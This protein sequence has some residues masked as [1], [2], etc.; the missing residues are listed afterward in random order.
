MTDEYTADGIVSKN[1][2]TMHSTKFLRA[3]GKMQRSVDGVVKTTQNPFLKNWYA[4]LKDVINTLN[5]IFEQHEFCFSQMVRGY[6]LL[7]VVEHA[8]TGEFRFSIYP[9]KPKKD[10][11]HGFAGA[12]TY[13]KRIS[14]LAI[15][16]L[17]TIDDDG[18][19]ASDVQERVYTEPSKDPKYAQVVAQLKAERLKQK[20]NII[21]LDKFILT[22]NNFLL[23]GKTT[24]KDIERF[25]SDNISLEDARE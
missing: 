20:K 9:L 14:L 17:P 15:V 2:R 11:D 8:E 25:I 24:T 7:T 12:I 23:S 19:A 13:A 1:I 22:I 21:E 10:D 16:G 5:P 6:E 4:T 3:W 18:N